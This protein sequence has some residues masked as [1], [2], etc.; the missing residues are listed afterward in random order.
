MQL[1]ESGLHGPTFEVK[2][3]CFKNI[4]AKFIPGLPF[5]EDGMA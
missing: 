2:R 4:G 5:G 1:H 3:C